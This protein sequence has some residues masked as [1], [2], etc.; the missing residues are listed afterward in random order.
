MITCISLT[1][2]YC[3]YII[4]D[5]YESTAV[6]YYPERAGGEIESVS[7]RDLMDDAVEILRQKRM[8]AIVEDRTGSRDCCGRCF[9]KC[10]HGVFAEGQKEGKYKLIGRRVKTSFA[11]NTVSIS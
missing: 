1:F 10:D 8:L 9:R 2:I 6:L 4:P 7:E 3:I 11:G 5:T